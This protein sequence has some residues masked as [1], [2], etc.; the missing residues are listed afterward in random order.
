MLEWLR[1]FL[2]CHAVTM[3]LGKPYIKDIKGM[4]THLFLEFVGKNLLN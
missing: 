1:D 4:Q 2:G 3:I